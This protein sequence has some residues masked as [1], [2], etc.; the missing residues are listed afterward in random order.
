[1]SS[2]SIQNFSNQDPESVIK[3]FRSIQVP[4]EDKAYNMENEKRTKKENHKEK[5]NHSE[6]VADGLLDGRRSFFLTTCL[7]STLAFIHVTKRH[8]QME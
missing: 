3:S 5:K 1:M 2:N 8:I 6:R 7:H 4:T